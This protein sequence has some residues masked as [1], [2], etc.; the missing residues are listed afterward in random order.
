[1]KI[2]EDG[3]QIASVEDLQECNLEMQNWT[4]G[5]GQR[6]FLVL[7]RTEKNKKGGLKY[8]LGLF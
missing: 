4:D 8:G 5:C 3:V 6:K 7:R 1:V 2:E